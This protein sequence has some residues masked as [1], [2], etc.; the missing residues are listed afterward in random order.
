MKYPRDITQLV[1]QITETPGVHRA[2][3][4]KLGGSRLSPVVVWPNKFKATEPIILN[5]N[6]F[7]FAEG[8]WYLQRDGDQNVIPALNL[9]RAQ[10][11]LAPL[12]GVAEMMGGSLNRDGLWSGDIQFGFTD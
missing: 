10:T 7:L 12:S 4:L 5:E 8:E 6:H 3:I 1:N 2:F 11:G 9:I